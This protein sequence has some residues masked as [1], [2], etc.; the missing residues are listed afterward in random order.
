MIPDAI[1]NDGVGKM[2]TSHIQDISNMVLSPFI[3][4]SPSQ[5]SPAIDESSGYD[6]QTSETDGPSADERKSVRSTTAETQTVE[7]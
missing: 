4:T 7:S 3:P 1:E 2:M 6:L 5:L